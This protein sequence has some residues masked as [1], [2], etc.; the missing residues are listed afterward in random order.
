MIN[1]NLGISSIQQVY[2][3]VIISMKTDIYYTHPSMLTKVQ[4]F[5]IVW[6]LSSGIFSM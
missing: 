3:V 2:N 5:F 1:N 4:L 6:I